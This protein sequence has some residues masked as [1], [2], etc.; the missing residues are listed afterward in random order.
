MIYRLGVHVS[1]V[2]V[3]VSR[4]EYAQ[5]YPTQCNNKGRRPRASTPLPP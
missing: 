3:H 5:T 4:A 1:Q 2:G